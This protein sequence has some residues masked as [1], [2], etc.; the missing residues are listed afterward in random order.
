MLEN[1]LG[2]VRV[3]GSGSIDLLT[4]RG[5]SEISYV[6]NSPVTAHASLVVAEGDFKVEAERQG[7]WNN[8]RSGK[9]TASPASS[10]G[11]EVEIR[12]TR[13]SRALLINSPLDYYITSI[14]VIRKKIHDNVDLQAQGHTLKSLIYAASRYEKDEHHLGPLYPLP[15]IL[16]FTRPRLPLIIRLN[17][18]DEE[19]TMQDANQ[20]DEE[21]IRQL[22]ECARDILPI[23]EY[24]RKLVV[25]KE[26]I[27]L[28]FNFTAFKAG[29]LHSEGGTTT[30]GISGPFSLEGTTYTSG[31]IKGRGKVRL[32]GRMEKLSLPSSVNVESDFARITGDLYFIRTDEIA[33]N[34][35]TSVQLSPAQVSLSSVVKEEVNPRYL[36]GVGMV[37]LSCLGIGFIPATVLSPFYLNPVV[38]PPMMLGALP[39]TLITCLGPRFYHFT[40]AQDRKIVS[41]TTIRTQY[42]GNLYTGNMK[43]A[44]FS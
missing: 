24:S 41:D 12:S 33:K 14:G 27:G 18:L 16:G 32:V 8:F 1:Y 37:A 17:E 29:E 40:K 35:L 9:V 7:S 36:A 34:W 39:L 28:P 31:R 20:Q 26:P 6:S 2:N 30:I 11:L 21:V 13:Q 22:Q 5:R 38:V 4:L 42:T 19:Q 10:S 23:W 15:E 44:A 3:D 43:Q 25:L